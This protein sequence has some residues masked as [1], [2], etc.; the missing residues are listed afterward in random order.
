MACWSKCWIRSEPGVPAEGIYDSV[1]LFSWKIILVSVNTS[2]HTSP[3]EFEIYLAAMLANTIIYVVYKYKELKIKND[4]EKMSILD[5]AALHYISVKKIHD[6]RKSFWLQICKK[7][8]KLFLLL[9]WNYA[10]SQAAF[11][12]SCLLA[13]ATTA[14]SSCCNSICWRCSC[15]LLGIA[16]ILKITNF[17]A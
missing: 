14:T 11:R 13:A 5:F 12:S 15:S 6:G 8:I 16:I 3:F 4:E 7:H 1:I 17:T 2:V 10:E 9:H